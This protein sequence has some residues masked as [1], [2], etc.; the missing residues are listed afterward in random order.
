M[1]RADTARLDQVVG[2]KYRITR[3]LGGGAFADVYEAVHDQLGQRF[4]IKIMRRDYSVIPELV[5]RF[6]L[7]ARAASAAG[8]PGIIQIFDIGELE[9]G[10]PYLVMELLHGEN[11]AELLK[12]RHRLPPVRAIGLCLHILDALEAA[13]AAGVIHRDLKPENVML[14]RGPDGEPWAKLVDFGVAR[15]L[16][17]GP[18]AT[19]LT[20]P[21]T[22]L[23]T[24][25][26]VAPEQAGGSETVDARADLYAVGAMLYEMVTGRVPYPGKS[27]A[28]ILCK[29]LGEPFPSARAVD[30]E[31]PVS[32]E[33]AINRACARDR[34]LRYGSAA[35]F[36]AALRDVLEELE[37]P[38]GADGNERSVARRRDAPVA[39][40]SEL[41]LG[42]P[43]VRR[44]PRVSI[45]DP[46]ELGSV[47][48]RATLRPPA[49]TGYR[50]LL[51]VASAAAAVV[52]AVALLVVAARNDG[53]SAAR[54]SGTPAPDVAAPAGDAGAAAEAA[55]DA[56]A[57]MDA[58][59]G[60]T[61]NVRSTGR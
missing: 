43:E 37:G 25:Y 5:Q 14:V 38:L 6:I 45:S 53:S 13:H 51:Y 32:L 20:A 40:A 44:P 22:L 35:E 56:E 49:G 16:Q 60:E 36:A 48:S 61:D 29:V 42:A 17:E 46:P 59:D 50:T 10:E 15:M 1:A 28:D 4:A 26:Y 27:V 47:T 8:H 34:D 57:S 41:R 9:S 33:A 54:T 31:I 21:G 52:A 58:T 24:P 12:R 18:N 55:A 39:A 19:R 11:L 23:G 3:R 2:G 7:E 30:P